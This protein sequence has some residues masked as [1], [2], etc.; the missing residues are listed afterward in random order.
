MYKFDHLIK[1]VGIVCELGSHEIILYA[2]RNCNY[3]FKKNIKYLF[4]ESVRISLL[5]IKGKWSR[6]MGNFVHNLT[7]CDYLNSGLQIAN[8]LLLNL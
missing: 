6:K 8:Y 2:V 4:L 3:M 1:C 7:L 5:D